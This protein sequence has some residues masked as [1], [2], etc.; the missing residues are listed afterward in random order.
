[1]NTSHKLITRLMANRLSEW[2]EENNK[3]SPYQVAYRKGFGCESHGLALNA[4]LQS[5]IN[6]QNGNFLLYLWIFLRRLTVLVSL[7]YGLG[8]KYWYT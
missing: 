7:N 8:K 6:T 4:I 2:C 1:V 3:V 5:K